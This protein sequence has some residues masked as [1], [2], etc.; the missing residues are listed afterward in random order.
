VSF[1]DEAN[2]VRPEPVAYLGDTGELSADYRPA[3][4]SASLTTKSGVRSSFIAPGSS[5]AG[6]FGLFQ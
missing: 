2:W 3:G 5:T 4:S 1:S 6:D